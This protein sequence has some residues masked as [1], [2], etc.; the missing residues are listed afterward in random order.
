MQIERSYG[1]GLSNNT[2]K[3]IAML[4]MMMDHIGLYFFDNATP[5]RAIGRLAFPIFSYMIAEGCRYT[6][7]RAKYLGMIAG[8]A[9]VMQVVYYIAM[10]SLY[11]CILVTFSLSIAV[12]YSIDEYLKRKSLLAGV[13]AALLIVASIFL[14]LIAPEIF[15]EEGFDLDYGIIGVILPIA[16]YYAPDKSS[17][18]FLT[19]L[20]L[21]AHSVIGTPVQWFSLL[22]LPLL[23][24]YNGRRG[25]YRM[26]YRFYIFY[27]V[28]LVLIYF[29][30]LII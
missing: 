13:I 29:I 22:S 17:R 16:V 1:R 11:Q 9:L 19:F 8:L 28:H 12:I 3:I 24:L 30:S 4:A 2:L 21:I 27:P 26:K 5:F 18:L 20:V 25:K 15:K 6:K 23:A 14:S 7:N 10:Q